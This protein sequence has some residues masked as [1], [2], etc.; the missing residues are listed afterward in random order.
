MRLGGFSP[1]PWTLGG[2]EPR[3]KTLYDSLNQSLGTAYDTS[4]ESNVTAETMAE[5]RAL[6]AVWS[7][8]RRMALQTDA[9]RMS[10]FIGRWERILDLHPAPSDSDVARRAAIQAK[11]LAWIGPSAL[12]DLVTLIAGT[13]LIG[14]EFTDLVDAQI[15]WPENGYPNNWTSNTA[16]IVIRVQF[17]ANQTT[18]EFWNMRAR[19]TQALDD[20]LPA[21]ATF[22]IATFRPGGGNGF[23]LDERN[24]NYE[25]FAH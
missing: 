14:I 5:A 10:D 13:S 19:L 9:K 22:D 16:H 3:V 23:F 2:G 1:L 4:D 18:A 17:S 11:F 25:T 6:D 24:L 8:N 15:R 7:A 20:F 21:W 12:L